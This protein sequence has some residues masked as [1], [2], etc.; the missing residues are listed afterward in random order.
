M[1]A[2]TFNSI[3]EALDE[4]ENVYLYSRFTEYK[5]A[6]LLDILRILEL[7]QEAEDI[8]DPGNEAYIKAAGLAMLKH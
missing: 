6:E 1:N 4:F 3:L 7:L 5:D 2:A 8:L